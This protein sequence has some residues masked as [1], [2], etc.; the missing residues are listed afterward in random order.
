ML[1]VHPPHLWAA[2]NRAQGPGHSHAEQGHAWCPGEEYIRD[3]RALLLR[4]SLMKH[5]LVQVLHPC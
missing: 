1:R 2:I 5:D 3:T 4:A